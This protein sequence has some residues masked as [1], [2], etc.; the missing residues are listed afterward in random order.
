MAYIGSCV[1]LQNKTERLAHRYRQLM[2]V[3]VLNL[4]EIKIGSKT[5]DTVFLGLRSEIVDII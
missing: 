1:G 2:Q 3:P 5:C 4:H